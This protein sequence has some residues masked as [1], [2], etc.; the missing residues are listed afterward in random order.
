MASTISDFSYIQT[1][2]NLGSEQEVTHMYVLDIVEPSLL[3]FSELSVQISKLLTDDF[4]MY[5]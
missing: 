3:L 2:A 5:N 4:L 1:H